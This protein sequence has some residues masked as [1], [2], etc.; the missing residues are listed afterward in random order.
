MS[1]N[2]TFTHLT[3]KSAAVSVRATS[4]FAS[5][6][7][8]PRRLPF[9]RDNIQRSVT[10]LGATSHTRPTDQSHHSA[11]PLPPRSPRQPKRLFRQ[12]QE[13]VPR[14]TRSVHR[15]TPK[16][17]LIRPPSKPKAKSATSAIATTSPL[18]QPPRTVY[19]ATTASARA[20]ELTKTIPANEAM[21]LESREGGERTE[22][23]GAE[24]PVVPPRGTRREDDN[25]ASGHSTDAES[26]ASGRRGARIVV[27]RRLIR[28]TSVFRP[29]TEAELEEFL[30]RERY[31]EMVTC[32]AAAI[33]FP[34]A[35]ANAKP[36]VYEDLMSS[37]RELCAQC[38]NPF[39]T[40]KRP[41]IGRKGVRRVSSLLSKHLGLD[42]DTDHTLDISEM[43]ALDECT[44]VALFLKEIRRCRRDM[45]SSMH[46]KAHERTMDRTV[47]VERGREVRRAAKERRYGKRD[48]SEKYSRLLSQRRSL[49]ADDPA[50]MR[51]L[52]RQEHLLS[53]HVSNRK[54]KSVSQKCVL[55]EGA[56]NGGKYDIVDSNHDRERSCSEM[57]LRSKGAR[58]REETKDLGQSMGNIRGG[59]SGYSG[60]GYSKTVRI[61]E[62]DQSQSGQKSSS[63]TDRGETGETEE[64]EE[65]GT[66][67][68][69]ILT[70]I[71]P[72]D[73]S[74]GPD[75]E[76]GARR[77]T[78]YHMGSEA[79]G[80]AG[81]RRR[82]LT[83]G[84]NGGESNFLRR[85]RS[86]RWRTDE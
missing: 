28:G 71:E 46:D 52:I 61:A 67:G 84:V 2:P 77:G 24:L 51:A 54:R 83:R 16:T 10:T 33:N 36:L 80:Y 47:A 78:S 22:R 3:Y 6:R 49:S 66:N 43:A 86:L 85:L 30:Q 50:L 20:A 39:T 56:H 70:A 15:F 29:A 4:D 17:S 73:P 32:H 55:G 34:P 21:L 76:D 9:P 18:R 75:E 65:E 60:G 13:D 23:E 81:S 27:K 74:L 25:D 31:R 42:T 79:L 68:V 19:H 57:A 48:D 69:R 37:E 44:A 41:M 53:S 63:G 26:P 72:V 82:H 5:P 40:S 64:E 8:R 1:N 38:L 35:L 11:S 58:N 12:L 45:L 7:P 59:Q 62:N 14:R